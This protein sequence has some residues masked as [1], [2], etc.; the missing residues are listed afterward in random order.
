MRMLPFR[1]RSVLALFAAALPPTHVSAEQVEGLH[2]VHHDWEVACDNTRTC[3]AAGYQA[4]DAEFPVSVLLSRAG[5]PGTPVEGQLQLG[6]LEDAVPGAVGGSV[7]LQMEIAGTVVGDVDVPLNTLIAGLPAPLTAALLDA[8]PGTATLRF[9]GSARTWT[10]SNRG[11]AA[12]LLKMDAFQGRLGTPGALLRK[13]E[14]DEAAVPSALP[15][16]Q[17]QA[18]AMDGRAIPELAADASLRAALMVAADEDCDT[19]LMAAGAL[20]VERI[21]ARRALAS[22]PC[23]Q[24]A[25]NGGSAYWVIATTPPFQPLLVSGSIS[26]REASQ[27]IAAHKGRGIGDCWSQQTWT[28]DGIRFAVTGASITGQCKM[29]AAGGAWELPTVVTGVI[30]PHPGQ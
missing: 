15:V 13:G 7:T 3:R 8:L 14:G 6:S 24:G 25:Y 17:V 18:V 4:D 9:V 22:L 30:P 19:E 5:G 27:L 12:V 10:L 21:D 2:F 1:P 23:W 28:W 16:P 26:E 11:A 20:A 29:L